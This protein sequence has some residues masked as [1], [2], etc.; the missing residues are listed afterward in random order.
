MSGGRCRRCWL[1]SS[2]LAALIVALTLGSS[3][4]TVAATTAAE[5]EAGASSSPLIDYFGDWF[6]RADKSRAEQP[7]WAPAIATTFPCLQE[8]F[9]YDV[10]R[11]TL[12]NGH[13][14]TSFGS[15][16]GLE[17]IPAENVQF[18]VG[19]PAWQTQNTTPRKEGWA[20][21]TFLMKYRLWSANEE[22]GNY[23]VTAFMG[24]S[25]PNGSDNYTT[26]HFVFTPTAAVGKGW[27]DFDIQSTFG[28]SVPDNDAGRRTLGTPLALNAT[29]QY[30]IAKVL[31][32]EV[33][34]NYT[35]W[36]NGTHEGL[37]QA[38]ITPGLILGKFPLWGRVGVTI[39]A[40]CQFAVT[41]HPLYRRNIILTGRI[42][43]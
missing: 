24:L 13:K 36:P 19:L 4:E 1:A 20:D 32:P 26:H 17:F 21:E 6:T 15:G 23:V 16:K 25:V 8:V 41:D 39:G 9:R 28:V 7:H 10:S 40:G 3:I 33:E 2:S 18:I 14:L 42:P 34:L 38:F 30:R 27:G 35:Y 37:N 43:F 29:A 11:E 31:W 12:A 5:A 22:N